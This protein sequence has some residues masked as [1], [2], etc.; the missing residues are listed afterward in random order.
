MWVR[1]DSPEHI[2]LVVLWTNLRIPVWARR[3]KTIWLMSEPRNF[4]H[5]RNHLLN[6]G[7]MNE[8]DK[9]EFTCIDPESGHS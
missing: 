9:Y 3:N 8:W 5:R 2:A 6:P 4:E 1:L 7:K